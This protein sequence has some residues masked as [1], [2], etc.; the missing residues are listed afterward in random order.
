MVSVVYE[1]PES[2]SDAI[3]L[4]ANA[5]IKANILAGGTDLIIQMR[6]RVNE[7][8]LVIDVK[9]IPEMVTATCDDSGLTLGP[10]MNCADFTARDDIKAMFPGLVESAYLIGSTQVQGRCSVGGN[11]CN[12]SPAADTIPALFVIGAQCIIA[13]PNGERTV[14]VEDFVTGV[15][16]NCL[17]KG[18]LLRSITIA[19]PAPRTAD[20]YLRLIPRTEMDIAVVGAG[21]SVTLDD[22]GICTAARVAIGAVAQ[23]ALLVPEAAAALVGTSIDDAAQQAAAYAAS[24]ASKPITDR[25]GTIEYRRHVVGVL[26][27]RAASIAADRARSK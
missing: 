19:R 14:A 11:L 8:Q 6:S 23:T 3:G 17:E 18:E 21:V 22:A 27:R 1:T 4:L 2:I 5:D 26:T 25:R 7:S 24:A 12:S 9:K 16:Q 15:G 20:A 13:G 10:A